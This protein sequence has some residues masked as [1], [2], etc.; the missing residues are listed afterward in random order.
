MINF[1]KKGIGFFVFIFLF[2]CNQE[3]Q[4]SPTDSP[5]NGQIHISVDES[6]NPIIDRQI[7]MYE[8][9][10]PGTKIIP[11]YKS[12]ADCINDFFHDSLNSLVIVTRYLNDNERKYFKDSLQGE[13]RMD[14]LAY[15]AVAIVVNNKSADT[16]FTIDYLKKI[17]LGQAEKNK[18]AVFDGFNA[19]STVRFAIDSILGG[20]KLDASAVRA[21][22]NNKEVLNYVAENPNAIGF[23]GFSWIGNPEIP[24]QVEMLKKVKIASVQCRNCDKAAY[25]KPSPYNIATREYPLVRGL[26]YILKDRYE[27]LG[28]GFT[29]FLKYERGQ[30]IFRRGYL[31]V[32]M[33]LAIREVLLDSAVKKQ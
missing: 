21:V 23:V 18:V 11:H 19:T 26:Y 16:A 14:K 5:T 25:I 17:L 7:N 4:N 33:G 8:A 3:K 12:E 27:G 6:F 32:T 28:Y 15:D 1:L 24:E 13:P 9:T 31:G 30:L 2:S 20:Q 10:W 22:S 29:T